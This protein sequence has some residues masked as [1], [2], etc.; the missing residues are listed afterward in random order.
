MGGDYDYDSSWIS[1]GYDIAEAFHYHDLH[2]K[3][4]EM[5]E[6]RRRDNCGG[7]EDGCDKD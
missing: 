6:D 5:V 7:L 1:G 3:E 2:H 4:A